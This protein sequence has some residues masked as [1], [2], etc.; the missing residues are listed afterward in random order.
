[1]ATIR[2]YRDKW[3][4]IVRRKGYPLKARSFTLKRDAE[5]WSREQE[6]LIDLGQWA[7]LDELRRTKLSDLI[8]RYAM[9]V[10]P[11][12][13][14][15][16]SEAYRLAFLKTITPSKLSVAAITSQHVAEWRDERLKTVKSGTVLRDLQ[17]LNN[18]FNVAIREWGLPLSRNPVAHIRKPP[19]GKHRDRV[20]TDCERFALLSSCGQCSNPWI[21]PVVT[22]ALETACRR[23]EILSLR[24][25]DVDLKAATAVVDG[26]TG[27]RKIPLSERCIALLRGVPRH[28]NGLVFPVS[29]EALK[30]AYERAVKRAG[31]TDFTFHDLRHDALTRLAR[32]GLNILELRAISG[33]TTANMLQRYVTINPSE[34][35]AKINQRG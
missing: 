19:Q 4:A 15:R 9:E 5:R 14:S 20:L 22:F 13:R 10:T 33:H 34:L 6:R 23:G 11:N 1:M 32:Q 21:L 3:Q 18:I 17:L 25:E 16:Y 12:K 24:W 28:L 30:Q 8:D 7:D 35:A 27:P 31:I 26:K 29:I 2:L